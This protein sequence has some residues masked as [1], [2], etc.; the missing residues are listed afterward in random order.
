MPRTGTAV[1]FRQASVGGACAD[2]RGRERGDLL[3]ARASTAGVFGLVG[4]MFVEQNFAER[5][6]QSSCFHVGQA[7][8]SA[9]GEFDLDRLGC[10]SP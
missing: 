5:C 4:R 1:G 6:A 7:G 2:S 3:A 10:S 8:D 9:A